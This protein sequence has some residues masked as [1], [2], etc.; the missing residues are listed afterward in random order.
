MHDTHALPLLYSFRR[1]PYA[2]RARLAIA[3]AGVAVLV[4]EVALRDKPQALLNLSPKGTVPVLRLPDGQVIEQS[5]DIMK[6]ALRQ[7]DPQAWLRTSPNDDLIDTNDGPFKH[8]LDRYKYAQRH[9]QHSA[10]HYREQAVQVLV[11]PLEDRLKHQAFLGGS[12]PCL[13]DVALFPFIRQ[14]AAVDSTWFEL[15]QWSHTRQWLAGWAT[16]ALFAQVM[17]KPTP[18]HANTADYCGVKFDTF[19]N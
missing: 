5:L 15:S 9:P 6:W 19:T 8:W 1:C 14:F 17:A 18:G 12:Q 16:S 7:H 2:I 10:S 11:A 3:Q 13:A 4:H